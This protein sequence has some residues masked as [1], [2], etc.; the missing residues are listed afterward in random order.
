MLLAILVMLQISH[1]FIV[2]RLVRF[3]KWLMSAKNNL[4]L[5]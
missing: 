3:I 5:P 2:D 1:G 4:Y